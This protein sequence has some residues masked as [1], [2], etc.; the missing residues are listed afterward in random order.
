MDYVDKRKAYNYCCGADKIA[1][2]LKNRFI[3]FI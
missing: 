2:N 1:E 3:N